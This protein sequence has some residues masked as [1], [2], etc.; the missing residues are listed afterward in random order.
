MILLIHEKK[1]KNKQSANV[2]VSFIH[3]KET[4]AEKAVPAVT[5][6]DFNTDYSMNLIFSKFDKVFQ[7]ETINEVYNTYP[8]FIPFQETDGMNMNDYILQYEFLL[9]EQVKLQS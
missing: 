5:T 7:N 9:L 6:A 3:R 2:A 4:K 1:T 8:K